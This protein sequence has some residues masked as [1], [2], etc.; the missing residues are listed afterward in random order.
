VAGAVLA[1]Q[2][3]TVTAPPP[4]Q[5]FCTSCGAPVRAADKFCGACGQPMAAGPQTILA[6]QARN[7]PWDELRERLITATTG[8]YEIKG[9][10]GRGGMA[11]VYLAHDLALGRKVAIKVMLPGLLYTERMA[12]RFLQEAR[13]AARLDH[14][15]IVLVHSVK[16]RERL[17]Y[18]VMKY[19]D[20]AALDD[21]V[22]DH[23]PLPVSVVRRV[24]QQVA[25]ALH[26]A[27]GAGVIH[28]D[29]KPAN[30]LVDGR[31]QAIVSDFGIA[32]AAEA[33]H[34]TQTG[35]TIGTPS[36]MSPEQCTGGEL[37]A[38]ADQYSLGIVAY[39][40]LTGKPPFSGT[41]FELQM[42]HVHEAPAPL[43]DLRPDCP[44]ALSDAV[45]RALAKKPEHRWPTLKAFAGNLGD[46][47][48]DEESAAQGLLVSYV[49]GRDGATRMGFPPTPRSPIPLAPETPVSKVMA[50]APTAASAESREAPTL[51]GEADPRLRPTAKL[52]PGATAP[53]RAAAGPS[54]RGLLIGAGAFVA[55]AA[56]AVVAFRPKPEPPRAVTVQEMIDSAK[57]KA[58]R[59]SIARDSVIRAE[60]ERGGPIP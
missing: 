5:T 1:G 48:P 53:P 47:S 7:G 46:N 10:L 15:H 54:R 27:H 44:P 23:A 24:L 55:V 36:Y 8:E 34:L 32:R 20:G 3:S 56:V 38:A 25:G 39:E 6:A 60:E 59:D 41:L 50:V 40:L 4:A 52:P 12:E 35:S 14:P 42:A 43:R 2:F 49:A 22:R 11:A 37:S 17:L 51:L 33:Q 21:V 19:I 18:F 26:H 9:E 58:V 16:E 30:I 45:L 28:R 31:G 13:T 57:A 29:I